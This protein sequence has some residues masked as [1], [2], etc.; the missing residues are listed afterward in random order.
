MSSE[1]QNT[2]L[3]HIC[4]LRGT[5]TEWITRDQRRSISPRTNCDGQFATEHAPWDNLHLPNNSQ[6]IVTYISSRCK[7]L[8]TLKSCQTCAANVVCRLPA[9]SRLR[10]C[11]VP[12]YFV[13]SL[14]RSIVLGLATMHPRSVVVVVVS[15]LLLLGQ[16]AARMH[17]TPDGFR[18]RSGARQTDHASQQV[19]CGT[20]CCWGGPQHSRCGLSSAREED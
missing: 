13:T 3:H 11:L 14:H 20:I 5:S 8:A 19:R 4:G 1:Q 6:H 17:G 15:V 10:P 18:R 7:P 16:C 12:D 9:P 2:S